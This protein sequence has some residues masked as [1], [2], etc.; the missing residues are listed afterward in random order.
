MIRPLR[1]GLA[2]AGLSL[3]LAAD[4]AAELARLR[5]LV[6]EHA[7]GMNFSSIKS[8]DGKV[9]NDVIVTAVT[10]TSVTFHHEQGEVTLAAEDCPD[11][12]VELFGFGAK[13]AP[14]EETPR[15]AS[16][17]P[18]D[19][20]VAEAIAVIEGD[21]GTGTGFFC[22]DG[23]T[24][25]LYSAA[26]VLSGNSRLKVKLRDGTVVRKFGSLEAAEGADL[27]RLPVNESVPKVLEIA[28]AS[29]VAKV[30]TPVLASGN[31]GGGG[32]VGFEQGKVMGVG[33]ESIEIDAQVIQGNSGG[34]IIHGD[35]HQVLGVVTHLTAE[36]KDLWAKGTRFAD[37]RRFG[38]RLDRTWQWK[39][40]PVDAFLKEGKAVLAV[41]E[42]SELM[43]AAMQP[44]KWKDAVFQRQ[45][46]NPL[47]RDIA[48]LQLWIDQNAQ[49][50]SEMDRKKRLRSIFDGARHRSS[51]QMAEF[52]CDGYTW[53]HRETGQQEIKTRE[54]IEKAYDDALKEMR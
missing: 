13:A 26:H 36:R 22:R 43:L 24:T 41:Q 51:A 49:R 9:F 16:S 33:P 45:R 50:A 1:L 29:G 4:D 11:V 37:V 20:A 54:E 18:A 15:P 42:Q 40:V 44:G 27:I 3:P 5:T 23:D 52:K 38:C 35:T 10:G 46:E 48:A 17:K 6:R 34:P 31:A 12:W 8:Q 19:T 32:T 25:Y 39:Q 53:F 2:L 14:P 30:G 21:R 7:A 28:A 47:A